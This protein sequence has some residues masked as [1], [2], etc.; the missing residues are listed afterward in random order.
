MSRPS[1][2]KGSAKKKEKKKTPKQIIKELTEQNEQLTTEVESLRQQFNDL[3]DKLG[4]VT[5]KLILNTSN[6]A[7]LGIFEETDINHISTDVLLEMIERLAVKRKIYDVSVEQ[8]VDDVEN[9]LTNL[10]MDSAKMMKKILAYESGL[11]SITACSNMEQMKDTIYK[12]QLIAGQ[13]V[14]SFEANDPS[15]KPDFVLSDHHDPRPSS[16]V[17]KSLEAAHLLNLVSAPPLKKY[18]GDTH[19]KK[20]HGE[21][22]VYIQN[23]LSMEKASG[24]DWRRIAERIGISGEE[25]EGWRSEN[26][27]CPMGRVLD[28]WAGE[29][30]A[31][32]RLLHR[33][34]MSPQMR[35]TL[36]GKRVATF[37]DVD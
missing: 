9:R 28:T 5:K 22:R 13:S 30:S 23:E 35:C 14:H 3:Q 33:H 25:V 29:P 21:L 18:P 16:P 26:L 27:K 6:K 1:S 34:L 31:T 2:R 36:L 24:A 32:V 19:I 8:R 4:A 15:K 11:E 17:R 12:L 20:M 37:Y 7:E 10:T